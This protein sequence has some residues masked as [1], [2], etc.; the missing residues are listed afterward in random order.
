MSDKSCADNHRRAERSGR[1]KRMALGASAYV[2]KPFKSFELQETI[3]KII[4][5]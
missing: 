5:T 1:Q 4:G 2:T 3:K